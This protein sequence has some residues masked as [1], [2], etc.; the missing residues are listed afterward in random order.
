MKATASVPATALVT[1][2]API[3]WGTTYV[4]ITELLPDGRPLLVAAVRVLPAGLA[5]LVAGRLTSPWRPRGA[6]WA[7]T[8][9]LAATN[10]A[11]FFPLLVLAVYR[12]PGGVAAAAGGLQPLL[13][14]GLSWAIA[15]RRP[16]SF[17]MLVGIAA[18]AGVALV[19]V[20]PGTGFDT[21]GVVAAV[22][23]NVSFAVGVVL[24]KRS[25]APP[26]PL[27]ATGWQ[28]VLSAAVLVPLAAL[29]EGP[30]P[31]P[32]LSSLAG[33]TYLALGATAFAFVV[34]FRG[35]RRLPAVAPPLLGLAAPVTGAVLGWTI[36]GESLTPTQVA[37]FAVTITAIA[38]GTTW[39]AREDT[40]PA[41]VA[42]PR[43]T[44][45][46]VQGDPVGV[47]Q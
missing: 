28:L 20:R 26:N 6:D 40:T 35:I 32:T 29:V 24:T 21:L 23:A 30:P 43:R 31:M 7:H 3:S 4:T 44:N 42:E 37:G 45:S 17:E 11:L 1:A 18:A 25:P 36:L 38:V 34:W 9:L 13:V 46:T 2:L 47:V 14:V 10:F 39:A 16:R 15:A 33:F 19:I 12:L 22:A 5:L 27:A 8:A 41:A